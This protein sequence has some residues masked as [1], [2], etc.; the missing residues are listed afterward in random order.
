MGALEY[1]LVKESSTEL[2][3]QQFDKVKYV[4]DKFFILDRTAYNQPI[5]NHIYVFQ[6]E[7]PM[8]LKGYRFNFGS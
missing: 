6:P 1:V 8:T 5:D 4:A 2:M 3:C 7:N